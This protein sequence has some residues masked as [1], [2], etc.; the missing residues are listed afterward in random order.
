MLLR[1]DDAQGSLEQVV[2]VVRQP[3]D[4]RVL[5]EQPVLAAGELARARDGLLNLQA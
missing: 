5:A 2:G 4:A 3:V 1:Q